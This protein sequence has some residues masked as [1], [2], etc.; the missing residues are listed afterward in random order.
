MSVKY[1]N[2]HSR[3]DFFTHNFRHGAYTQMSKTADGVR[4]LETRV[5][6]AMISAADTAQMHRLHIFQPSRLPS[7]FFSPL[8]STV[9]FALFPSFYLFLSLSLLL[10]LFPTHYSPLRWGQRTSP[11][12]PTTIPDGDHIPT[13]ES[14]KAGKPINYSLSAINPLGRRYSRKNNAPISRA[15]WCLHLR[16]IF[17]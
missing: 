16:G 14:K 11:E 5:T 7:P 1:A 12:D 9:L 15:R 3:R 10:P 17:P 2:V 6:S 4:V 13:E 8:L